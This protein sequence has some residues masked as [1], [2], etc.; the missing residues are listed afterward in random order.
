MDSKPKS[1][2]FFAP[3][4][5]AVAPSP[6]HR[7]Q[8]G[9]D[10]ELH[11]SGIS[12]QRIAATA[13]TPGVRGQ[14]IPGLDFHVVNLGRQQF[15]TAI[16]VHERLPAARAGLTAVHSPGVGEPAIITTNRASLPSNRRNRCSAHRSE[17]E[18]AESV[19]E[20]CYGFVKL[21]EINDSLQ[22]YQKPFSIP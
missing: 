9:F 2:S 11:T 15:L 10:I 12:L 17:T 13:T 20:C 6:F 22:A 5:E 8:S 14:Q 18:A 1:K 16:L 3:R 21:R 7:H 19:L 4:L